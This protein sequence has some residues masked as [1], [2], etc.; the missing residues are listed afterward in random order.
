MKAK[1]ALVL[2]PLTDSTLRLAKQMGVT[3]I[4]SG[5]PPSEGKAVWDILSLLRIKNAV[6]DAGLKLTVMEGAPPMEKAKLGLP[7][8]DEEISN[9][10]LSIKNM[11]K[12][13]IPIV[14]YNFMAGFGWMRTSTS[15][16]GRGD[17]RAT[18]FDYDLIKDAPPTEFG[19]ISEEQMWENYKYFIGKVMPVAEEAKVKMALHPDDPPLSPILGIGR[20]FTNVEAF[21]RALEIAPSEYHGL[22]FCQGCF[23]EMNADIPKT[24]HHFGDRKKIFFAHFR[25]LRGDA[26]NF[27]ETFHDEG[28]TDMFAAM[29]AYHEIDFDGPFRPD[30]VPEMEGDPIDRPGYTVQGRLF[31]VGY[32][33]GLMSAV[34][35]LYS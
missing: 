1:L 21:D 19:T 35:S 11:G 7:G 32:M 24:V 18:S 3:D 13:G 4:V 22:T 34:D 8:R 23:A 15:T 28:K 20:L 17:A 26:R 14:C 12:A 16:R 31:A 29:K 27:V 25:D 6:E 10:C 33:K 5:I 2:N 30:H 9:F